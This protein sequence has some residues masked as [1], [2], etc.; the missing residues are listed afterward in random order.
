MSQN[1]VKVLTTN[2]P[3]KQSKNTLDELPEI[4]ET[5]RPPKIIKSTERKYKRPRAGNIQMAPNLR[6][7]PV[8]IE[9]GW[10]IK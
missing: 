4:S 6:G 1:I 2:R 10:K 8:V 3:P 5:T 9:N 7:K